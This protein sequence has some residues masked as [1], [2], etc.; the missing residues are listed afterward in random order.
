MS[1]ETYTFV[2]VIAN[3]NNIVTISA[4]TYIFQISDTLPY[5]QQ[6]MSPP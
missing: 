5:K 3:N 1:P 4:I 2:I 6:F